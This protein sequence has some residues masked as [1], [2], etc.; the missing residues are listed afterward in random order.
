MSYG[1][2]SYIFYDDDFDTVYDEFYFEKYSCFSEPK[3]LNYYKT[4]YLSHNTLTFLL[5]NRDAVQTL[6]KNNKNVLRHLL[7]REY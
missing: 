4:S 6:L 7:N 3:K 2:K 5:T 1:T